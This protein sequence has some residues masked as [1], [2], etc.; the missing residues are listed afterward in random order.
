MLRRRRSWTASRRIRR[1][2]QRSGVKAYPYP[3]LL[4]LLAAP[5]VQLPFQVAGVIVMATLVLVALA[6]LFVADVRDWRCYG[7]VLLW[8]PVISAIQTG[9]VTLWFALALAL[10]WRF[11]NRLL[12][13]SASLGVTLAAKFFLWPVVVWMAATRAG[14]VCGSRVRGRRCAAPRLVGGDRFRRA[15]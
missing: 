3:P 8:P 6:V 2:N 13:P 7:L 11:R 14:T 15:R 1:A 12:S 9:N 4:A 5:V 10:V